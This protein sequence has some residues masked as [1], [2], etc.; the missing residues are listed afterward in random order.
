MEE[1]IVKVL[2]QVGFPAFVA[3]WLLVKTDRE[4]SGHTKALN[5][6]T[7]AIREAVNEWRKHGDH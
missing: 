5:E 7:T 1:S 4:L 6:L 3:L 2:A